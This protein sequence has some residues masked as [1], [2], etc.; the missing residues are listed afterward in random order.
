MKTNV[1]FSRLLARLVSEL[2][3]FCAKIVEYFK[4]NQNT[5]YVR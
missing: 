5:F 1:H 2:E 4:I 3:M